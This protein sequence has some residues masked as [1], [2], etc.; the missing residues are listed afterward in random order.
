MRRTIVPLVAVLVLVISACSRSI[1]GPAR[2]AAA[3][4]LRGAPAL[5]QTQVR[6]AALRV[7]EAYR[8]TVLGGDDLQELAATPL[9]RRFAYWLGVTNSAFPGQMTASSMVN[10]VGPAAA[11]EGSDG[12]V[13]VDMSAQVDVTALPPEGEPLEL[14]VPLDGPIRLGAS[15]PG[16]WRV[17]DFVRFGV[18]VSGAFVP[19][20]LPYRRPG[21]HIT[22]DS[23]GGVPN[24][25]FF[26]RVSATGPQVLTLDEADVVLVDADGRVVGEAIDVSSTLLEVAPGGRIDGALSFEPLDDVGG[27]SLRIDLSG[28]KGPAPLEIPLRAVTRAGP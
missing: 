1:D 8:A 5:L 25:S 4:E 10:A 9:M 7:V 28:S 18:P 26:V 27:V 19:L 16:E 6:A 21:V 3:A 23:F 2:P 14:S 24:W 22:L 11:V 15:A 17:I 13:E 20:D 12:V